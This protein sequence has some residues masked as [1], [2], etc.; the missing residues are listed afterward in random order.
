MR[1]VRPVVE[2][3]ADLRARVRDLSRLQEVATVLVRHG[4]GML[5]AGVDIPGL[6]TAALVPRSY[7]STPDRV[8]AA[9]QELGPTFVKLGQ[10]MSTRPDVLPPEYIAV[11]EQLQD[12]VTPV[13]FAEV[14]GTLEHELGPG[15]RDRV[16]VLHEEPL[17]TASVA[18][19]HRAT[20]PDGRD[21]VF[22]VQ[23]RG[24]AKKILA[25][26][27]ILEFLARRA[28]HEYP[29]VRA[30]DPIGVLDEFER[31]IFSELDFEE[32][33]DNARRIARNFADKPDLV[34][35]PDI[36]Q[37]LSTRRVLCMEFLD[38]TKIRQARAAGFDMAEVGG[39]YLQVAYDMLF[40]H[41]F[42]HGDLHPGNV[43]VLPDGR[44]G[45]LD[46]GMV[47]RLTQ[48][49]RENVIQVIFALQ[50]GDYRTVARIFYDV[51]IKEERVDYRAVERDTVALMDK[52]WSGSSIRE[53]RMG[54]YVVEL[55][56]RA[57]RRG[58][59]IPSAYT[60]FFKAIVTSEG[61]A[62]SLIDE[63]DPIQAAEPYIRRFLRQ[64]L[65]EERLR[66]ELLY[67]SLTLGSLARR[68]PGSVSQ[69]LD[70]LE[71]QRLRVQVQ[72]PDLAQKIAAADRRTNRALLAAM[73]IGAF[74]CGTV[75]LFADPFHPWGVPVISLLFY[76][77]GGMLGGLAFLM[78][79]RNRGVRRG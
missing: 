70:D 56:G 20:L 30:F 52:Y 78:V 27:H 39:K 67:S 75:A 2:T 14:E 22:K 25:D 53:L 7:Q 48:E 61:L 28:L 32:E 19:V 29:E 77:L 79:L 41:G 60:M 5:V 43:I 13:P 16:A 63:V 36:V 11:L 46:F 4:L 12:Q 55:A 74:A 69:L 73:S 49:M 1:F 65:S 40:E 59:R 62:K 38:G 35:I 51:S 72:D 64:Q 8:L 50:R 37:D 54:P 33:A 31:S 47:G 9:I 45:L 3:M 68:L 71:A 17:A 58:A 44:L 10:V 18:Q 15:W 34:H 24:I 26:I 6:N 23:R 42:F 66:Q 57:A 21:V 76:L